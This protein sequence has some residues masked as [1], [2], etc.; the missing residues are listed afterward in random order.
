MRW[1]LH[2]YVYRFLLAVGWFIF[3]LPGDS[4]CLDQEQNSDKKYKKRIAG[5]TRWTCEFHKL[6][7]D[8][9]ALATATFEWPGTTYGYLSLS[10]SMW[11]RDST[12]FFEPSSR[13]NSMM[14]CI[15]CWRGTLYLF[16]KMLRLFRSR[17]ET[18]T[19]TFA[20]FSFALF[21]ASIATA[22]PLAGGV[23]VRPSRSIFSCQFQIGK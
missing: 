23:K 11:T 7:F 17:T 2:T 18:K 6:L 4:K 13:M 19:K 1:D 8:T 10:K 20:N 12:T 9:I 3:C 21:F 5:A 14:S 16:A 15:N 22:S